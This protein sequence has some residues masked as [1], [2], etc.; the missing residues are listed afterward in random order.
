MELDV[1]W[2]GLGLFK[3]FNMTGETHQLNGLFHFLSVQGYRRK[4]LGDPLIMYFFRGFYL[5]AYFSRG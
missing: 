3:E 2:L 1:L 5:K 4:N